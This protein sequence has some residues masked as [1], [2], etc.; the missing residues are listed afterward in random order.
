MSM[1][2]QVS[3]WEVGQDYFSQEIVGLR[4]WHPPIYQA[5]NHFIKKTSLCHFH[6]G[7]AVEHQG[8]N[9][10][11]WSIFGFIDCSIDWINWPM[12]GPNGDYDGA[13]PKALGDVAQRV[14][15]TGYKNV[16]D[17]SWRWCFFPMASAPFLDSHWLVSMTSAVCCRWATL[18]H[19]WW[20]YSRVSRRYTARLVTAPI[21]PNIFSVFDLDSNHSSLVWISPLLKRYAT[22]GSSHAYRPLS[23]AMGMWRMFSRFVP[24]WRVIV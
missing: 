20:R 13:P 21:M 2:P 1:D 5:I 22:I 11:P 9:F 15:Y 6:D 14:V 24:T 10:L 19:F 8:L 3:R 12:S 7:T 16:T 17:W 23:G 18:M 4:R